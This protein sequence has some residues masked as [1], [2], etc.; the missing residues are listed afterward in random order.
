MLSH[1]LFSIISNILLY[2]LY[3]E[4]NIQRAPGPPVSTHMQFLS[5]SRAAVYTER[6]ATVLATVYSNFKN[7]NG[8]ALPMH[9]A[10]ACMNCTRCIIL[11]YLCTFIFQLNMILCSSM[12]TYLEE[13][14][15]FHIAPVE[16]NKAIR[17]Q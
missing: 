4:Y 1:A 6:A 3:D 11:V 9:Q 7:L 16:R 15:S 8:L 2:I 14:R 5:I 10:A 12:Q 17:L 13:A